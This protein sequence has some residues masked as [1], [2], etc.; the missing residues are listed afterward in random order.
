MKTRGKLRKDADPAALT[1]ATMASIQVGLL[2]T[3]VRRD[4]RQLRIALNAARAN[5]RL[6][7]AD[8]GPER[9]RYARSQPRL[10]GPRS[11]AAGTNRLGG[12]PE[13]APENRECPESPC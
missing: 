11:R 9:S 12:A 6:A 5:L 4:P 8:H 13:S 7:A 1:T 10:E 2:V 3:Q